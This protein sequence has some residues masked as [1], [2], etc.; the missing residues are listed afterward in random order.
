MF[1]AISKPE[2]T[3]NGQQYGLFED[4]IILCIEGGFV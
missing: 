4:V 2:Y 1:Y 3:C